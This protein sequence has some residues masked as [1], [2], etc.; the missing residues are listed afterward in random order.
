MPFVL[1]A[2]GAP[3]FADDED[4]AAIRSGKIPLS[5]LWQGP[6]PQQFTGPGNNAV[7]PLTA[8]DFPP[9]A[10]GGVA[11]D[12]GD[13]IGDIGGQLPGGGGGATPPPGGTAG[14]RGGGLQRQTQAGIPPGEIATTGGTGQVDTQAQQLKLIT[15]RFNGGEFANL[16]EVVL[17]I[18]RQF[19]I[20]R[21]DALPFLDVI[22]PD[23]TRTAADTTQ[24][25]TGG[26]GAAGGV[27]TPPVLPTPPPG[28]GAIGGGG[29]VGPQT[30]AE[31][32]AAQEPAELRRRL[33]ADQF[34][35]N[36]SPLAGR[37]ANFALNRFTGV[38][39]LLEFASAASGAKQNI[40]QRFAS[41]AGEGGPTGQ[42]IGSQLD[43]LSGVGGADP[44][45]AF[46][47]FVPDF[48][49]AARLG[50]Q[51]TL[52]GVNPRLARRIEDRRAREFAIRQAQQPEQ[53]QGDD[54]ASI[55]A[56]LQSTRDR[57]ARFFQ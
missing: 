40:G 23:F 1:L 42:E 47:N 17:E 5:A 54:A 15:D 26:V 56:Q 13:D 29:D 51:E 12:T 49:T 11:P 25:T 50:A 33:I 41:F 57:F 3:F 7:K 35:A 55:A 4:M 8:A 19:G 45:D 37:A 46:L 24:P 21:D 31:L 22:K 44:V 52:S 28:P 9:L 48:Q 39:P 27:P 18:A 10:T 2:N 53:F 20:S 34:G 14:G 6:L 32:F 16:D 30:R 43:L 38:D 36:L